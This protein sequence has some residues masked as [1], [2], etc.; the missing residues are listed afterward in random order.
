MSVYAEVQPIYITGEFNLVPDTAAWH[1]VPPQTLQTGSW[2]EQ[3]MPLYGH[4][5]V[6]TKEFDVQDTKKKYSINP[7]KWQGTVAL[8]K[9]NDK[10]VAILTGNETSIDITSYIR[11]GNNKAALIITG[12]LKNTLGPHYNKPNPGLVSPWH[13]RY[14]YKPIPGKDYDLYDY[15]LMEDFKVVSW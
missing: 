14:V 13:W 3:G 5:V 6:Y 15:G 1:I 7:G 9:V 10:Q 4:E 2:K 8:L 12:S 11:A